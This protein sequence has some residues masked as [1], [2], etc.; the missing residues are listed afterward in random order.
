LIALAR[1]LPSPYHQNGTLCT[2]KDIILKNQIIM[3]LKLKITIQYIN[4]IASPDILILPSFASSLR[5]I[6][7]E[8]ISHLDLGSNLPRF[9][10]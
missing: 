6:G 3:A 1:V 4:D 9:I 5:R 2:F 10:F 7:L 8:G